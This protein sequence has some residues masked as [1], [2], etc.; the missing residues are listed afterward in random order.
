MERLPKR[1]EVV[2]L[3][4]PF[5]DLSASKNRPVLILQPTTRGDMITCQI[6]SRDYADPQAI[7]LGPNDFVEGGLP[8]V[9]YVQ[10]RKLFTA[11]A[12]LMTRPAGIIR[13]QVLEAVIEHV[14]SLLRG[15]QG[16]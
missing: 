8:L 4:F 10:A 3:P 11:H 12:S 6:S 9:S 13:I 16:K 2:F 7:T 1:G 14:V 15:Q 5:S